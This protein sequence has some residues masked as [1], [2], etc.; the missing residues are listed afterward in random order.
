MLLDSIIKQIAE[1]NIQ[2]FI[3]AHQNRATREK[4]LELACGFVGTSQQYAFLMQALQ[5]ELA[6]ESRS[7]DR[8]LV[9]A[10]KQSAQEDTA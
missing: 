2:G 6:H 3:E 7:L 9:S 4:Y 10:L 1:K 5:V 8:R